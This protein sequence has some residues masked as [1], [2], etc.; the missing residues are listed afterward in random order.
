MIS[1]SLFSTIRKLI[2]SKNKTVIVSFCRMNPPT[3]GHLRLMEKLTELGKLYNAQALLYLS[4]ST[5]SKKNPL[6]YSYKLDFISKI[7]PKK[8]K[9]MKSEAKNIFDVLKSVV[10]LGASDVI[11]VAGSDRI[12]EFERFRKYAPELGLSDI[13]IVSAGDRDPDSDADSIEGISATKLR[14][15]ALA[16][17]FHNFE[18]NCASFNDHRLSRDLFHTT[19]KGLGL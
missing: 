19:R 2:E 4:H 9:V 16:D 18:K 17:D 8:L 14:G 5:D 6:S 7:A 11:I 15:F 12:K 1:F 10:K 13:S 3:K